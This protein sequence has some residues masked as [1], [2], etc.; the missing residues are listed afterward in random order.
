M[1]SCA[2][3]GI[4]A[5]VVNTVQGDK[6]L[7]SRRTF[8]SVAAHSVHDSVSAAAPA[9]AATSA[10]PLRVLPKALLQVA[11]TVD[12]RV[13][14]AAVPAPATAASPAPAIPLQAIPE[15]DH[16]KEANG[17]YSF[18][19]PLYGKQSAVERLGIDRDEDGTVGVDEAVKKADD[20]PATNIKRAVKGTPVEDEVEDI[21]NKVKE[22]E[23]M[24]RWIFLLVIVLIFLMQF[25]IAACIGFLY[26]RFKM[27]V[28]V[29]SPADAASNEPDF[30]YGFFDCGCK[31]KLDSKDLEM[32]VCTVCPCAVLGNYFPC[33]LFARW[34]D[35]VSSTKLGHGQGLWG[36]WPMYLIM[37]ALVL[38]AEV[39]YGA[40]LLI[41]VGLAM[42]LRHK[43]RTVYGLQQ[44]EAKS[45]F[46]DFA[47]WCCCPAC[48]VFQE[49][50]Q[51]EKIKPR[52]L[53]PPPQEHG[54]QQ[55]QQQQGQRQPQPQQQQQPQHPQQPQQQ[56][57]PAPG[58][59]VADMM[60]RAASHDR[61][62][63][64]YD[65]S[66]AMAPPAYGCYGTAS[67][68]VPGP[69]F[70]PPASYPLAD[71][72]PG[73]RVQSPPPPPLRTH[74]LPACSQGQAGLA[75]EHQNQQARARM[76]SPPPKARHGCGY[77]Q[78]GGAYHHAGE[79]ASGRV[80][81]LVPVGPQHSRDHR[82]AT[83]PLR[84]CD[85]PVPTVNPPGSSAYTA[86][87]L[88]QP[89]TMPG[90]LPGM[91]RAPSSVSNLHGV[92][93]TARGPPPSQPVANVQT[94]A[95]WM[96]GGATCGTAVKQQQQHS[97]QQQQ[98][99]NTSM[100]PY[101]PP[102][103][104]NVDAVAQ[105]V[106]DEIRQ[107]RNDNNSFARH[108]QPA[109]HRD[110]E[111]S[112]HHQ[113]Q[114]TQ[115]RDEMQQTI[116]QQNDQEH[117][118]IKRRHQ[119]LES[120]LALKEAELMEA[121]ANHEREVAQ[122]ECT[123]G[124]LQR[125]RSELRTEKERWDVEKENNENRYRVETDRH[126]EWHKKIKSE[127]DKK[128]EELR[129]T[130]VEKSK[131][132]MKVR[133]LERRDRENRQEN[134][135]LRADS[136]RLLEDLKQS[137][138]RNAQLAALNAKLQEQTI[139]LDGKANAVKTE[140][141]EAMKCIEA[142]QQQNDAMQRDFRR[143]RQKAAVLAER[144]EE[145]RKTVWRMEREQKQGENTSKLL[146]PVEHARLLKAHE[147]ESFAKR[148]ADL[149]FELESME[150]SL[151]QAHRRIEERDLT[152]QE[153]RG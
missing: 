59:G 17:G 105:I 75:P 117:E 126:E 103:R 129:E 67:P 143:E 63:P 118:Q 13:S 114:H 55:Q 151:K 16:E 12:D 36:F 134:T 137:Q 87:S 142:L 122:H 27:K 147:G 72:H 73:C 11:H 90:A 25:A 77:D 88:A 115:Q 94:I 78:G 153:L 48:A 18:E 53:P 84:H 61:A 101:R 131:A 37:V 2:I 56:W 106:S 41:V 113:T 124:D 51:V 76:W 141:Q 68:P 152:I 39:T 86:N 45:Y 23:K 10:L 7:R 15:V 145:F 71:K 46:C 28:L 20:S 130:K 14:A 40:T 57:V 8:A 3:I 132:A 104:S 29:E 108:V 22:V 112:V 31:R 128:N 109:T 58:S 95:P 127:F 43:I 64:P 62:L 1:K 135:N 38:L 50:R 150:R 149:M 4:L 123:K 102:D 69:S 82:T 30:H 139:D 44:S 92:P 26:L 110:I 133:D 89:A 136:E 42:Y 111:V 119:E 116:E 138:N 54:D 33:V 66:Q 47:A 120:R 52:P 79:S 9:A 93:A 96:L 107:Q 24:G 60:R 146:A 19:S 99:Q 97:P 49:A 70:Q 144:N 34:A 140:W 121:Q 35:T 74:P 65:P 32:C 98:Q 125:I 21:E 6:L 81:P 148:N 85:G 83:S 91:L 80:M 100:P 5:L